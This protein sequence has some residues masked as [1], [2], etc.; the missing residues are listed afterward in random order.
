MALL[1]VKPSGPFLRTL[2]FNATYDCTLELITSF[3]N[4]WFLNVSICGMPRISSPASCSAKTVVLI[5]LEHPCPGVLCRVTCD[6]FAHIRVN[7]ALSC[8]PGLA[9][10][11]C[12]MVTWAV[13]YKMLGRIFPRWNAY[14]KYWSAW[15]TSCNNEMMTQEQ[16][17]LNTSNSL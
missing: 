12:G 13:K 7:S 17:K 3:L 4:R 2:K 9:V 16:D 8:K 14:C 15:Y 1:N 6:S 5:I 10:K 11:D